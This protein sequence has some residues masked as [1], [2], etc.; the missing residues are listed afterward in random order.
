MIHVRQFKERIKVEVLCI[1]S[2]KSEV[3]LLEFGSLCL[4]AK[5]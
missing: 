4:G 1:K 3:N 5:L 2:Y